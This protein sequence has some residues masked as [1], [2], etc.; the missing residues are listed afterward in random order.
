MARKGEQQ[1]PSA[2]EIDALLKQEMKGT[3]NGPSKSQPLKKGKGRK[4]SSGRSNG[5]G[6]P[7]GLIFLLILLVIGALAAA[8]LRFV[9]PSLGTEL[10]FGIGQKQTPG[11]GEVFTLEGLPEVQEDPFA[12]IGD[13]GQETS[14][15]QPVEET[16][17]AAPEAPAVSF[18]PEEKP[19][20]ATTDEKKSFE[21]PEP[22]KDVAGWLKGVT[23]SPYLAF[24][25]N[26][27]KSGAYTFLKK[28]QPGAPVNL[29]MFLMSTLQAI[30]T[31][32]GIVVSLP[33][34]KKLFLNKVVEIITQPFKKLGS[35]YGNVVETVSSNNETLKTIINAAVFFAV[36]YAIALAINNSKIT[37]VVTTLI[38]IAASGLGVYVLVQLTKGIGSVADSGVSFGTK[39]V[40]EGAT[41]VKK[42]IKLAFCVMLFLIGLG[43]LALPAFPLESGTFLAKAA[44]A[45]DN[46]MM[47]IRIGFAG[48]ALAGILAL[49]SSFNLSE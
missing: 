48:G 20:Q 24:Y 35:G 12:S 5:G 2:E 32:L 26:I 7:K 45:L 42:L 28:G 38:V 6:P 37:T 49:L 18:V 19:V 46:V 1:L 23:T 27:F 4:R 3:P 14:E 22:V 8:F 21:M 11:S 36:M 40:N 15:Q 39:V 41:F 17:P 33:L 13:N 16:Q 44:V 9:A 30:L 47:P 25:S 43:V 34:A 10:P 31:G 29:E